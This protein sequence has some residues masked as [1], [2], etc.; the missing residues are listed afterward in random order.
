[1]DNKGAVDLANSWSVGGLTRHVDVAFSQR[2]E[3]SRPVANKT[4]A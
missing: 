2:D 4:F 3:G 1:M